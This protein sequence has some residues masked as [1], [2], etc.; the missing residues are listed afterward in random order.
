MLCEAVDSVLSQSYRPIE[1]I[2]VDDGST[3]E[4]SDVADELQAQ[5]PNSVKSLHIRNSGPGIARE[6]GRRVAKGGYIQYLDSDDLLLPEKFRLQVAGLDSSPQC[7]ISYCRTRY[8]DSTGNIVDEAW[9]RTGERIESLFPSMLCGRWW[10]TSTPLYR[11]S[12]VDDGGPWSEL[13]NEE[14]W[15][16]DCRLAAKGVKLHYVPETLSEQRGCA[17]NRLSESGGLDPDKLSSRARAH[18]MVYRHAV[19]SGMDSSSPE[20]RHFSR[21]LFLLSRQCGAAGLTD[22]SKSL[23]DLS[24]KVAESHAGANI[25]YFVYRVGARLLGWRIMGTASRYFDRARRSR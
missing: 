5:S 3:D 12:A 13:I 11:R 24:F 2:I 15:E 17:A 19:A 18:E 10:G 22:A 16:Y 21:S 7:A 1:I 14:D 23:F 4:T 8:R 9:K 25:E 6:A 20:M